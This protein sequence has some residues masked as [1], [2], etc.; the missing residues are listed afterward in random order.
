[1][2]KLKTAST[3]V[4]DFEKLYPLSHDKLEQFLNTKNEVYSL[5]RGQRLVYY[6]G[7]VPKDHLG[8]RLLQMAN[9]A[10]EFGLIRLFQ[11][12]IGEQSRRNQ[13]GGIE[14]SGV[15]EY[16]AEGR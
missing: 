2:P 7:L 10:H 6:K 11:R 14:V 3:T 9:E 1:M 16:I 13:K 15:F 8:R 12:K 4:M 5:G